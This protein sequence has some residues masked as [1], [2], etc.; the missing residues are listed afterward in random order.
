MSH[1]LDSKP[2]SYEEEA[3]QQVWKDAMVDEYQSIVKNDVWEIVPRPDGNFVVSSKWIFKIKHVAD[4]SIEKYKVRLWLEDSIRK[5]ELITMRR[6]HRLLVI[7]LSG[8]S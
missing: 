4:G 8:R 7:H 3:G 5:R 6:L 1:I 2:S